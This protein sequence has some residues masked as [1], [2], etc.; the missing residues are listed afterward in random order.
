MSAHPRCDKC[1]WVDTLRGVHP[2][3]CSEPSL[4]QSLP[5]QVMRA[6]AGHC[7]PG[8]GLWQRR[9]PYEMRKDDPD[10]DL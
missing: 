9:A 8:G 10:A 2:M 6:A 5:C 1:R 4:R 7:G 3:R